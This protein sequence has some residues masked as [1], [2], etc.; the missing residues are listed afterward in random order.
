MR[1]DRLIL[2]ALMLLVVISGVGIWYFFFKIEEKAYEQLVLEKANFSD[3]KGWNE[4][5]LRPFL[6]AFQTSCKKILRLPATRSLG[7]D[8]LAG[9]AQD[10][11]DLCENVLELGADSAEIRTFLEDNFT[12]FA[13]SNAGDPWGLFTGYYEASLKG[14]RI[15]SETYATPL[16][17]RPDELVMV[18][19]G[20]FRD[21]LKGQRIAGVV[22]NG[23][24]Y[25]FADRKEIEE[26]ALAGR[27]LEIVW[28]DSAV[29]AFFLHIQGSGL[30]ELDDGS[31][32]RVGYAAQNGHPYY[33]IG[34]TLIENG[35]VAR[36]DMSMQAI[37]DW[38]EANPDKA[39]DLMQENA[40]YIFFRELS[41][42]GPIGAQGVELTPK[43][44][45]AVDRKWMPLGV[46]VW[47]QTEVFAG[48]SQTDPDPFNHLMM[49]QDTGG[50]IR[51]PV[52]GDVFWGHGRDAY[53]AAGS[54]KSK[55][56]YWILLPNSL[57]KQKNL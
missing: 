36:E 53:D 48:P 45:L 34:K 2:S 41:T 57:V 19:L 11:S 46:P 26:G 49:A 54:M 24:L 25:P 56:R 10:W 40:S 47:L 37:R 38:L 32:L 8:G 27:D 50:A 9:K 31:Q 17:L 43:R 3:L 52:R 23:Q 15:R 28:V 16:Y 20:R 33:A 21:S 51:G 13:V 30:I 29:D 35:A 44:S 18:D 39:S 4:D 55:G 7:A 42:S 12:P 5:D 14:S 1:K 22:K 6:S